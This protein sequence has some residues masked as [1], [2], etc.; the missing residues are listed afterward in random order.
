MLKC[1]V[2]SCVVCL[3]FVYDFGIC[4][5]LHVVGVFCMCGSLRRLWSMCV[6]GFV[7]ALML[8]TFIRCSGLSKFVRVCV[9]LFEFIN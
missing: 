3:V 9:L 7:V 1:V 4:L 6:S 8:C 2:C 5:Y